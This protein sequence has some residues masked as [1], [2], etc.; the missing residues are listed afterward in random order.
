M[1]IALEK[2]NATEALIK[3]TLKQDD[4]QQ[5]VD[6]KIKDY[7]KKA[8]IK[9]FRPGKVP[10]G[11]IRKMYGKSIL[12]DEINALLS[13]NLM[14][15]IQKSDL[16]VLAE[17]VPNVEKSENI[18]WDNQQDFEFE[19]NIGFA[20]DFEVKVDDSLELDLY[21]IEVTDEV[22]NETIE[23]VTSQFGE[24]NPV[25]KAEET[26]AVRA[27]LK[28]GE[29]FDKEVSLE[30]AKLEKS[31]VKALKG[32]AVEDEVTLK[33]GKDIS[34]DYLATISGGERFE[35]K[36]EGLFKIVAV[37]RVTPAE[38]NDELFKKAFPGEEI[39]DEEQF[40]T[41]VK[42][43]IGTNY[44]RES[45]FFFNQKTREKLIE[46]AG[47]AL[48]DQFLRD[49]LL[50][51]SEQ[52]D[53]ENIETQYNYYADELRWSLIKGEI[54]EGSAIEVNQEEVLEEAKNMI[55]LQFAQSG[56]P[57]EQL[58]SSLDG[59]AMNY[60]QGENGENYRK[61]HGQV[62]TQKVYSL[63]KEKAVLNEKTIGLEDFRNL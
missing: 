7:S 39:A 29:D 31:G 19:Y 10:Q 32:K 62:E 51:T 61:V 6:E 60:L 58:E 30:I 28:I 46:N 36:T 16:K 42:E 59:F 20:D 56:M 27:G 5:T 11:M 53:A 45:E 48:P 49:F 18:D 43:I 1:D 37:E 14:E 4:Y 40:R 63:I 17:P 34:A 50:R 25:D 44:D 41:R 55:K 3:I 9:G 57:I 13:K 26:D 12:V 24:V 47:I 8:N 33:V 2:I 22:V 38:L 15:Y 35:E 54:M 21:S 23:N 52:I